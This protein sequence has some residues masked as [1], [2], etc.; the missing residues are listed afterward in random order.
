[1]A[2][3]RKC[4]MKPTY[5]WAVVSENGS[6]CVRSYQGQKAIHTRH[7]SAI[8]DCANDQYVVRVRITEVKRVR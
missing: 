3:K 5:A 6:V 4:Q 8:M 1:M 2:G 7:D